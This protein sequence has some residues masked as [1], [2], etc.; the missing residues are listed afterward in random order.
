MTI[1]FSSMCKL[2]SSFWNPRA[3]IFEQFHAVSKHFIKT[4]TQCVNFMPRMTAPN[5]ER[6][7][8]SNPRA[9]F[10]SVLLRPCR[11]GVLSLAAVPAESSRRQNSGRR[12]SLRE[13]DW[14]PQQQKLVQTVEETVAQPPPGP[15]LTAAFDTMSAAAG[16]AQFCPA[17]FVMRSSSRTRGGLLFLPSSS[18]SWIAALSIASQ[19]G[20]LLIQMSAKHTWSPYDHYNLKRA[21]AV[22]LGM[23]LEPRNTAC[24]HTQYN[25][26]RTCAPA[27]QLDSRTS[28]STSREPWEVDNPREPGDVVTSLALWPFHFSFPLH[29]PASESRLQS[30]TNSNNYCVHK[31]LFCVSMSH[32]R[33][34]ALLKQ[35]LKKLS[36]NFKKNPNIVTNIIRV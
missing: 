25:P 29:C 9:N 14:P 34:V 23:L 16:G 27:C 3:T 17:I 35:T 24:A 26:E 22:F 28:E 6:T 15:A 11:G 31:H 7:Q 4:W 20:T 36:V 8:V 2:L 13:R 30:I 21:K 32:Q 18:S 33:C 1:F 10:I 12:P 19:F 5:I